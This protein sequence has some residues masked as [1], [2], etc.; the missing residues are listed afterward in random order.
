MW[1]LHKHKSRLP[2][3]WSSDGSPLLG[4]KTIHCSIKEPF[5][6]VSRSAQVW[7]A[8]LFSTTITGNLKK[9]VIEFTAAYGNCYWSREAQQWGYWHRNGTIQLLPEC[10]KWR[11]VEGG[12]KGVKNFL[13]MLK[14]QSG[15]E[16]YFLPA[17]LS[18]LH[19][20]NCSFRWNM[21]KT[22]HYQLSS[23]VCWEYLESRGRTAEMLPF[24]QFLRASSSTE[25]LKSDSI[26]DSVSGVRHAMFGWSITSLSH[27]DR[28][29]PRFQGRRFFT[30]MDSVAR[31]L[32]LQHHS[33][34]GLV[35]NGLALL[36]T[37]WPSGAKLNTTGNRAAVSESGCKHVNYTNSK[38]QT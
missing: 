9:A 15:E 3:R 34:V 20:F 26:C 10:L 28:K 18:S 23:C 14:S 7:R 30:Q 5:A 12:R 29:E 4:N 36:F 32:W 35:V 31:N 21:N 37:R 6:K 22:F 33:D 38:T 17:A 16:E 1:C 27:T 11:N 19:S 24:L 25:P 13:R 8:P 2:C